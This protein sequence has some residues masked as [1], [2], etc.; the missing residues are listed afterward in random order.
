MI[1]PLYGS[2]AYEKGQPYHLPEACKGSWVDDVTVDFSNPG[3]RM[4]GFEPLDSAGLKIFENR[5]YFTKTYV[6]RKRM[7]HNRSSARKF[8]R[9]YCFV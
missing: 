1:A 7:R 8:Y 2:I 9:V 6:N 4:K 3:A 5:P